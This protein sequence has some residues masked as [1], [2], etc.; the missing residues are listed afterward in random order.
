M[1]DAL[2]AA[3]DM[4]ARRTSM[5]SL[6]RWAPVAGLALSVAC[7]EPLSDVAELSEV[8]QPLTAPPF[9]SIG[10]EAQPSY[11]DNNV[12]ALTFD[13]GPDWNN[14][15]RVLDVL[16]D[17]DVKATFFINSKNWSDLEMDQPMR[18]LVV[19]MIEEGHDLASHTKAHTDLATLSAE[20]VEAEVMAV[21]TVVN[22]ILGATAPRLT[23]LRAP[24]G[25][26]YQTPVEP[27][28]TT[29]SQVVARHAI[30]IGWAIDTFDYNC[31]GN[32]ACVVTNF[33]N[34]VKTPGTGAYGQVL[35]HSVHAQTAGA[36][37]EIIDYSRDSGFV[38]MTTEEMVCAAFGKPSANVVDNTPG[39]C[40]DGPGPT[41][42]AGVADAGA[43]SPD[44]RRADAR[45]G[46]DDDG[47]GPDA[48]EGDDDGDDDEPG[49][50]QGADDDD[51]TGGC[52]CR[53]G[54]DA[55]RGGMVIAAAALAWMLRRRR[56]LA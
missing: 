21:E 40:A 5:L 50:D 20:A 54:D 39:S 8:E 12:L 36:L 1:E 42:D 23:K 22:S 51:L 28:L 2:A 16:R 37:Q 31:A 18:A 30:H 29:V 17:N 35:M 41:P 9:P 48:G 46:G 32:P 33:K 3:E 47:D 43:G 34:A 27:Q 53:G 4:A 24:F 11:I 25:S 45:E 13:D 49:Q 10:F 7:T 55:S 56:P 38:F 52:G 6:L 44:A 19:R 26:P 15:A 14:T